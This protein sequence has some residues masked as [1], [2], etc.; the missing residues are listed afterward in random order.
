MKTT[1][2]GPGMLVLALGLSGLAAPAAAQESA[3]E[4]ER[5]EAAERR[6]IIREE[7]RAADEARSAAETERLRAAEERLAAAEERLAEAARE[8]AEITSGVVPGAVE[9]ARGVIA[10]ARRPVLGVSIG[11]GAGEGEGPVEGVEV[12]GVSPGSAAAEAGIRAG[13]VLTAVD[14]ESLAAED[15][16]A[17]N[18]RLLQ[19]LAER[20]PGD[21]IDIELR[22]G[23]GQELRLGVK[24]RDREAQAFTFFG[25]G[26]NFDFDFRADAPM[27]WF[28]PARPWGD[29]ELVELSPGLGRYFGTDSGLL[30]VRAP[31]DPALKL[32][33]GDVIRRIGGREPGSVS[34]AI[35]I[36]RSYEEGEELELEIMREQR[37]RKLSVQIPASQGRLAPPPRLPALPG[38]R[39]PAAA[40]ER[41][42][43]PPPQADFGLPE[44]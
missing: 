21:T 28:G 10:S 7:R 42:P 36:L 24:T 18:R 32:E 31:S 44:V 14:G 15:P 6:V 17:A 5:E 23:D 37:S 11:G 34:H 2:A 35:R 33:D 19:A 39:P 40:P 8:I 27:V 1:I 12:L 3:A 25:D 4:A 22:R 30:V 16:A 13:D 29:M 41:A 9:Y 38:I 26:A 20:E 43:A